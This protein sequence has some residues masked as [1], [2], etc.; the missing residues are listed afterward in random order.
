MTRLNRVRMRR[1]LDPRDIGRIIVA[2]LVLKPD[3]GTRITS[4]TRDNPRGPNWSQ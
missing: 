4:D 2:E 3:L 1:A